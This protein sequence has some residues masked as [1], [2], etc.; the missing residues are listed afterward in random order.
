[1]PDY[2]EKIQKRMG[3]LRWKKRERP[4][5]G[6]EHI[7]RGTYNGVEITHRIFGTQEMVSKYF[8]REKPLILD[9]TKFIIDT[10]ADPTRSH[11]KLAEKEG[12]VLGRKEFHT[13]I[14][15]NDSKDSFCAGSSTVGEVGLKV[16]WTPYTGFSE[17]GGTG[18]WTT[19]VI[20]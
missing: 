1:M 17:L 15:L 12:I 3:L 16:F 2:R 7:G 9:A 6:P 11:R 19:L 18:N 8:E 20:G 13:N 5:T 10:F 4:E 14:V